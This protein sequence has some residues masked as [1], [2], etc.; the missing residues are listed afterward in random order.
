VNVDAL[1]T[2]F[3]ASPPFSAAVADLERRAAAVNVPPAVL[4]RAYTLFFMGYRPN[5]SPIAGGAN[6]ALDIIDDAAAAHFHATNAAAPAGAG[7]V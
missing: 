3:P 6:G 7:E 2:S 1:N 5:G 4:A